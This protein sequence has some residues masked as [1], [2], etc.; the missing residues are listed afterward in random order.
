[1]RT[2]AT[3][4]IAA[5]LAAG[6]GLLSGCQT[7]DVGTGIVST[8]LREDQSA[9]AADDATRLFEQASL[10]VRNEQYQRARQTLAALIKSQPG[11]VPAV[12]LLVEVSQQ[13]GDTR[14]QQAALKRLITLMP[15]S[16]TAQHRAGRELVRLARQQRLSLLEL[17]EL[18]ESPEVDIAAMLDEKWLSASPVEGDWRSGSAR[19]LSSRNRRET[20]I[21][22]SLALPGINPNDGEPEKSSGPIVLAGHSQL[23]DPSAVRANAAVRTTVLARDAEIG[24]SALRRAV[25]LEPRN[26]EFV[27][28]LFG[29]L[30]EAGR[31]DEAASVLRDA[32]QVNPRDSELPMIAARFHE[33]RGNEAAA[34]ASYDHALANA[35]DNRLWLRQ[36]GMCHYRN[37]NFKLAAADLSRALPQTPV[38]P[39]MAE[40]QAWIESS[41]QSEN[42]DEAERALRL[43]ADDDCETAETAMLSGLCRLRQGRV[44]DAAEIVL[45]ALSTWPAHAGLRRVAGMIDA[46]KQ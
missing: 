45:G 33:A 24:L 40:F 19:L 18:E 6:A 4:L 14:L 38:R 9:T 31:S 46:A 1:M 3:M 37:G 23:P 2:H 36:R 34:I 17:E 32:L 10:E 27:Q 44:Q 13:L 28:S 25:E 39:Q 35:P 5:L 22:T 12:Q 41:L 20:R 29:A 16:G 26:T 15:D 30:L 42:Y 11:N 7:S 43:M 8:C 21:G